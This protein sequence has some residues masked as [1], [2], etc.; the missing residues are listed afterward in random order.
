M[1]RR[2]GFSFCGEYSDQVGGIEAANLC[3]DLGDRERGFGEQR[4]C[5]FYSVLCLELSRACACDSLELDRIRG[6]GHSGDG[7]EFLY[8]D[9]A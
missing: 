3:G 2:G 7:G 5:L 9:M 8:G 1:L 6:A 4:F